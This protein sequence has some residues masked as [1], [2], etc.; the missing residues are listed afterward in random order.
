MTLD[1]LKLKIFKIYIFFKDE[2]IHTTCYISMYLLVR[3]I[4]NA[5][6]CN[7]DF[8]LIYK[9]ALFDKL[10]Y[11]ALILKKQQNKL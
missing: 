10:N 7:M 11:F 3:L 9:S 8:N 1:S 4:W 6:I 2:M 5:S